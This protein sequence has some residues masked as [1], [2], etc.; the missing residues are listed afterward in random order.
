MTWGSYV[1]VGY[2]GTR[3]SEQALRWAAEEARL[4]RLPLHVCYAWR[5]P[6][7]ASYL[8]HEGVGIVKRIG[9]HIL[10]HGVALARGM[11]PTVTMHKRLM[12]G[13]AYAALLQ[14]ANDAELIVVGSHEQDDLAVGSTAL[15]LP[16]RA[17]RPVV[18]VRR[19][20]TRFGEVVVGVDG[21]AGGDAALAFAFEEAALRGWRVRAVYGCWEPSAAADGELA[22]F[23]DEDE[24]GRVCT[25]RLE[26]AVT[27]WQAKY[28]QVEARTSLVMEAPR[29]ALFDAAEAADLVVV[30]TRSAGALDPLALGATSGALL[31]HVPCTVAIVQPVHGD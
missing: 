26:Q 20:G 13:P 28:P 2:D 27:P 10:D 16:A 25:I 22:L 29:Q 21:S 15:R 9:E 23:N 17:L 5:S 7:P 31:Q 4:R 8:D 19:T 24:L 6:Y 11:A 3:D 1:L 18:A 30:G 12:D 14:Q